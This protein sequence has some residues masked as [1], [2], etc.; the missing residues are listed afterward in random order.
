MIIGI[1]PGLG[2]ALVKI[3]N[4]GKLVS[5]LDMPVIDKKTGKKSKNIY[6]IKV[7]SGFISYLSTDNDIVFIEDTQ[8]MPPGFRGQA[9]YGLG[10]CKGLLIGML[11]MGKVPYELVWA[12]KWQK[13]FGITKPK[14]DKKV[15]SY[16]IASQLFPS[17][18]LT[19]PRG[20]KL[21]GRSD[22]LLIAEYGRRHLQGKI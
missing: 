10:L 3:T 17:A 22:A 6:D 11:S 15:Q 4:E 1:D 20:G 8:P 19:G 18:V 13:H 14:G 9:S 16:Q 2:G 21:D 12:Q 7:L 5:T